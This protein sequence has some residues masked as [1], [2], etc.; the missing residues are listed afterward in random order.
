MRRIIS[1]IALGLICSWSIAQ[2]R[3]TVPYSQSFEEVSGFYELREWVNESQVGYIQVLNSEGC[4]GAKALRVDTDIPLGIGS[5]LYAANMIDVTLM[6]DLLAGEKYVL[7][8]NWKGSFYLEQPAVNTS[9]DPQGFFIGRSWFN[10]ERELEGVYFSDDDGMSYTKVADIEHVYDV[11]S[12]KAIDVTRLA[13]EHSLTINNRFRIKFCYL[14]INGEVDYS[15]GHRRFFEIDNI[16]IGEFGSSVKRPY[17]V[18]FNYDKTGNRTD[19]IVE[20]VYS[21]ELK[22]TMTEK[23]EPEE[24]KMGDKIICIAPNPTQGELK[25]II[26]NGDASKKIDYTI[27]NVDGKLLEKGQMPGYGEQ[28]VH[29]EAYPSGIYILKLRDEGDKLTYKIIKE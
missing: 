26:T 17:Y 22:S 4:Q 6:L 11:W 1:L 18:S 9:F 16:E 8:Y 13:A 24:K 10:S 23:A 7:T 2:Q 21:G 12:F 28:P 20:L 29:L 3:V 14:C 19:K 15:P 5:N 27:H 25:V